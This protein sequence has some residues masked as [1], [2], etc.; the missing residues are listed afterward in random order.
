MPAGLLDLPAEYPFQHEAPVSA[1]LLHGSLGQHN[2]SGTFHITII[3]LLP[4]K[5]E[6]QVD[7]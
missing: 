5:Q 2:S 3:H 6:S 1:C 7:R 4:V